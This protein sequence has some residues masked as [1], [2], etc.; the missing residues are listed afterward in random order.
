MWDV[1][2]LHPV[3]K[4]IFTN[5]F[6]I[7]LFLLFF[8]PSGSA[9]GIIPEQSPEFPGWLLKDRG[10]D[11]F[12]ACCSL[13]PGSVNPS[14]LPPGFRNNAPGQSRFKGIAAVI[15]PV[16]A[17]EMDTSLNRGDN[18]GK[19]PE[20][21]P[22]DSTLNGAEEGG[23]QT[24]SSQF[25]EI[26][27]IQNSYR[28]E[29]FRNENASTFE[30]LKRAE[31]L[32]F[33]SQIAGMAFLL[34]IDVWETGRRPLADWKGSLRRA[35]TTPPD[36]DDDDIEFNYIGHPYTGAFTYNLMRSQ[37]ASPLAS[38]LF[39]CSQSLIWEF[40]IEALEEH[41]SMQDL[42]VTSNVGSLIGEGFHRLTA[43]MRKNGLTL[44][45]KII[46]S[47]INPGHVLNNGYN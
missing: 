16:S 9:S 14:R 5:L 2:T 12:Q 29:L 6:F 28:V 45:E 4:I 3:Q 41:P 30:K 44:P 7:L 19:S 10:P 39:S 38:W 8:N 46:V 11:S 42:L 25:P 37:N 24:Q 17:W 33:A 34:S 36:W 13:L 43:K 1:E 20:T 32:S 40:T 27:E 18:P 15:A 21:M 35:W 31:A 26:P 47:S 23:F 22:P